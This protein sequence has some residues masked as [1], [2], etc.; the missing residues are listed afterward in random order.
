MADA[1]TPLRS[2]S[3]RPSRWIDFIVSFPLRFYLLHALV[4]RAQN[5]ITVRYAPWSPNFMHSPL[6]FCTYT[7]SINPLLNTCLV[8]HFIVFVVCPSHGFFNKLTQLLCRVKEV[9]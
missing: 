4:A 6:A 7:S 1:S 9:C 2:R 5:L 3:G 8:G